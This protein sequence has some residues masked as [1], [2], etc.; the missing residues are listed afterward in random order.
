[1]TSG[2]EMYPQ[3]KRFLAPNERPPRIA[4]IVA[5]CGALLVLGPAALGAAQDTSVLLDARVAPA[6]GR[7]EAAVSAA[8]GEGLPQSWLLD[9]VR[10]GIAKHVAADRI[11]AA[12]DGLLGRM[13]VA[14]TL[15][16]FMPHQPAQARR[17]AVL[18]AIVDAL[19]AGAPAGE[20]GEIVRVAA[21]GDSA[22]AAQNIVRSMGAVAELGERGFAGAVAAQATKIA[23]EREGVA[24][25][26]ALVQEARRLS[27]IDPSTRDGLLRDAARSIGTDR[28]EQNRFERRIDRRGPPH[29]DSFGHGRGRGLRGRSKAR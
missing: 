18:R 1:M 9:K 6:R 4:R 12:V 21:R 15:T 16:R 8:R 2:I 19:A 7:I 13:R 23:F 3:R 27:R 14:N 29:D 22:N 11:A 5:L 24:G 10:E 26:S 28:A 17:D 25:L 20:L